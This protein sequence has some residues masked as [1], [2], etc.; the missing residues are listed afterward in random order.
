[1]SRTRAPFAPLYHAAVCLADPVF[2]IKTGFRSVRRVRLP[3]KGPFVL[4]CQ[5]AS[6][7]D[8][9]YAMRG[10][11]PRRMNAV[12]SQNFFIPRFLGRLLRLMGCI[13]IRQ[14]SP[15]PPAVK[16][17]LSVIRQG[18]GLLIFP[19][20]EVSGQGR[21]GPFLPG[22]P[23]LLKMLKAPTYF[24]RIRGA[25][26]TAPK[27]AKTRR[28]G[29]IET[30]LIPLL[31]LE[32]I[33]SLSCDKIASAVS[34]ALSYD[35]GEWQKQAMIPFRG[36]RLAEGLENMLHRCPKCGGLYTFR[37]SGDHIFCT[38]CNNRIRMDE[39]GF[40]RPESAADRAFST[41]S[42]WVAWQQAQILSEAAANGF[43][44]CSDVEIRV[45]VPEKGKKHICAGA[46]RLTLDRDGFRYT[47]SLRGTSVTLAFPIAEVFKC[48]FRAGK[49]FEIPN[50]G[51]IL[52]F[53]PPDGRMVSHFVQAVPVL[54][55]LNSTVYPA[56][57][58]GR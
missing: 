48:S 42:Q 2:R 13:S 29:K 3:R 49:D 16:S 41:V 54:R 53:A 9:I 30:E 4:L 43:A 15:D 22:L 8:F 11:W 12:V 31:S 10:A 21:T 25:Y 50:T 14:F 46:G 23:R 40:L 27:W 26:L 44:L 32:E 7:Y 19:E 37:S 34:R 45:N 55:E 35:E 38:A 6:N 24:M 51:E 52:A 39:Y 47:G 57:T 17:M 18:R 56:G 33:R 20:A 5:H 58:P 28:R 36:G 1:M